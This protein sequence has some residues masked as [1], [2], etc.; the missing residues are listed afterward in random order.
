MM[1]VPPALQRRAHPVS[2]LLASHCL[3][4][5]QCRLTSFCYEDPR[6]V[7]ESSSVGT[8][9]QQQWHAGTAVSAWLGAG[10]CNT[11]LR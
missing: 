5:F 7:A 11:C 4:S 10:S 9:S 3:S 6:K 1:T 8:L 2:R